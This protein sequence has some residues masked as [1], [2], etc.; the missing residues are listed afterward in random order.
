M[1]KGERK[2]R[3]TI[4]LLAA[5]VIFAAAGKTAQA[6]RSVTWITNLENF[7]CPVNESEADCIGDQVNQQWFAEQDQLCLQNGALKVNGV[8]WTTFSGTETFVYSSTDGTYVYLSG[9]LTTNFVTMTV[10][11]GH[12]SAPC[13]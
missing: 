10:S 8:N 5:F 1:Q 12:A 2:M 13:P 7:Q 11:P 4:F 3:R 6:Q 9:L